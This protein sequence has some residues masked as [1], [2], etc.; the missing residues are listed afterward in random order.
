MPTGDLSAALNS[1]AKSAMVPCRSTVH[2]FYGC[3]L[4]KDE[5]CGFATAAPNTGV[6]SAWSSLG[7][8]AS[9]FWEPKS[10][11]AASLARECPNR[12][13]DASLDFPLGAVVLNE[14]IMFA[15]CHAEAQAQLLPGGAAA[16]TTSIEQQ[17]TATPAASGVGASPASGATAPTPTQNSVQGRV[18][19]QEN[20]VIASAGLAAVVIS[21]TL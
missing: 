9:A 13:F 19:V 12:W 7:S 2:D 3:M 15:A 8:A 18:P 1:Y 17:P 6:L 20:W 11:A 4:A 14:T 16:S 5:W 21:T 10:S